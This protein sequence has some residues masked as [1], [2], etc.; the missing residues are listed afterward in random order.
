MP[1]DLNAGG[2]GGG[3]GG[4]NAGGGSAPL[5]PAGGTGGTPSGGA[6]GQGAP[7]GTG[8][9]PAA[10][11]P[12]WFDT[13]SP[14]NKG[15]VE[16]KGFKDPQTVVDAYR[17]LEKHL[18]VPKE[19]LLRLP[20][21]MADEKAMAEIHTRLGRPEKADGYDVTVPEGM[22]KSFAEWARG[23][24]HG[25]GLT[26]SQGDKLAA[27]WNERVAA[28]MTAFQESQG[29]AADQQKTALRQE[30]GAAF[31]QNVKQVAQFAEA[32]GVSPEQAQ[33]I[34]QAIGVDGLNKMF[35]GIMTKFGVTLGEHG[36]HGGEGGGGN[37]F[38]VLTPNAAM[39][40][41]RELG[42]DQDWTKKYLG[43]DIKAKAEM[44]RLHRWA[45]PESQ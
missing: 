44:E 29:A 25:L 31:D 4:A 24:F 7:P 13:F 20:E 6:G 18:G 5:T 23:Q 36:F 40:R 17:N 30:W 1:D 41:I 42:Q 34:A 15:F 26:K 12:A 35:L 33:S 38:G 32:A 27:G 10:G 43:G 37:S 3:Q 2:T 28:Q 39:A 14:E 22:D 11:T 16:L 19:R 21:N 9:A 8:G 45:Y